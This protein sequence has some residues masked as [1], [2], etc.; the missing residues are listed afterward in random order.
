MRDDA[1]V[2]SVA[3]AI[4]DAD[5]VDWQVVEGRA[6]G[7]VDAN[8]LKQLKRIATVRSSARPAE[9][10]PE[11]PLRGL[12]LAFW[13]ILLIAGLKTIAALAVPAAMD[14]TEDTLARMTPYLVGALVFGTGG[15]VLLLGGREDTRAV[16][17]GGVFLLSASAFADPIAILIM[18]RQPEA[19]ILFRGASTE[20]F[21]AFAFWLLLWTFPSVPSRSLER[22]IL[23][24]AL[25]VSWAVGTILLA[26]NLSLA[27][28]RLELMPQLPSWV[29]LLDRGNPQGWYW[30]PI[31]GLVLVAIPTLILKSWRESSANRRR[32]TVFVLALA[33]GVSP[34]LVS[35]L[36][37]TF[38]P[39]L[40]GLSEGW[41][42]F[43][44]YATLLSIVP[45]TAYA[46]AVHRV[47]RLRLIIRAAAQ[48]V[49][50][51]STVWLVGIAPLVYLVA[52][53]YRRP[54]LTVI[55]LL[56]TRGSMVLIP[57][58]VLGALALV[59]RH[60]WLRA[61]DRWFLRG[62]LDDAG[63]L[64]RFEQ[65]L[66]VAQGARDAG[67]A[68]VRAVQV[69]LHPSRT[70]VM[71]LTEDLT[72]FSSVAGR[73]AELPTAS[74]LGQTLMSRRDQTPLMFIPASAMEKLLPETDLQWLQT[75]R[76]QLLCAMRDSADH[77]VG[78]VAIGEHHH[79]LPYMRRHRDLLGTMTT[80]MARWV[81]NRSLRDSQ[82]S[83]TS[84]SGSR[85]VVRWANEP[86]TY[87]PA[88]NRVWP[89]HT[90]HCACGGDLAGAALPAAVNGKFSLEEV[91]GYGGSGVV[92]AA[93]DRALGRRVAI[94]TLPAGTGV[95]VER[96]QR[97]AQAMARV[98]HPNLAAIYGLEHWRDLPFLVVELLEGG[99]HAYRVGL[100]PLSPEETMDLGIVMA[101]VLDRVHSA[102]IL[103][104]DIKP[105]N[106]G[107]TSDGTP[108]LL[109]FGLAVLLGGSDETPDGP[110]RETSALDEA[111]MAEGALHAASTLTL[112]N[113]LLGTPLYMSP[114][115]LEGAAPNPSFDVW[116]LSLVLY[117]GLAG[118]HPF[119]GGTVA[120]VLTR[121]AA[122]QIPDARAF[123]AGCPGPVAEIFQRALSAD[124][125]DR[126]PSARALR[127]W[128]QEAR[129]AVLA[130]PA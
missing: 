110:T 79:A 89:A 92:Y 15:A 86:G 109:D 130:G 114:E 5:A 78:V 57:L 19:L 55:D 119:A 50:A 12:V 47:M 75:N 28:G 52:Q 90:A 117:E 68:L 29:S 33:A 46:V 111:I 98:V 26:A 82:E 41:S 40:I 42:R 76:F 35:V 129:S 31:F 105:S 84:A 27:L 70:S 48:Y 39:T 30:P 36:L 85:Q 10:P 34:M 88:C 97:E 9:R 123:S 17:L 101:D 37:T 95:P 59:F 112:S 99:T 106:I 81:E 64:A 45:M 1:W 94:K 16:C 62:S 121:I 61:I 2:E 25:G 128:L 8:V 116:S 54:E 91:I 4:A 125:T 80:A 72:A 32:S 14:M 122:C 104:R 96:L 18:S 24:V 23:T 103:H 126:P 83:N 44:I 69:G 63:L 65:E 6:A 115:A 107:Y 49:L 22:R 53:V 3:A 38:T 127:E 21:L 73:E 7:S 124:V 58:A 120:D 118:F 11:L 93:Y 113:Q 66:R 13:A 87:C 74:T 71:L 60:E 51:R 102:G 77:I 67:A 108:K 20:S 100:G 43:A 56:G